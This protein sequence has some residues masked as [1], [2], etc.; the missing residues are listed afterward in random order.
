MRSATGAGLVWPQ[1][2]H[3]FSRNA[4]P[5]DKA[6]VIKAAF[7]CAGHFIFAS[8]LDGEPIAQ[9]YVALDV[10]R[11][12]ETMTLALLELLQGRKTTFPQPVASAPDKSY[13]V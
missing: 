9:I 12:D 1:S 2:Q 10:Q 6:K 7:A 8:P 11:V 3:C 13:F 4:A 5:P